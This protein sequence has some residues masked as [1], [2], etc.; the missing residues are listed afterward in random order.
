MGCFYTG[1]D[2]KN[3]KNGYWKIGET[4]GKTPARR[5]AS[6]RQGDCFQCTGYLILHDE[7]TAERRLIESMVRVK[8]ERAGFEQVQNDHFLYSIEQ[9][10]KYEQAAEITM[11]VIAWAIE[12][13]EYIGLKYE[14]GA[15]Q[16]KRG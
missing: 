3:R 13:C 6:I 7:T 12:A 8:M 11:Q 2:Y 16:Y 1:F 14:I 15:K 9:G 4:S 5:L 10:R